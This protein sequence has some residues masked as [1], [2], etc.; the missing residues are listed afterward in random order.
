MR[1]YNF[2]NSEK[3]LTLVEVLVAMAI[4][5]LV[6][7]AFTQ[8][9]SWSFTNIFIQGNKSKATA[10]AAEKIDFL[11]YVISTSDT[12]EDVMESDDEWVAQ[13]DDLFDMELPGER[14]FYYEAVENSL[15]ETIVD[16]YNVTVVVFYQDYKF[17]VLFE[18]FIDKKALL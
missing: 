18:Q 9:M 6:V 5:S 4:L 12:P 11:T 13:F 16:G 15:N 14:R 3:G 17:H 1:G 2:L 8:L 7:V 10:A